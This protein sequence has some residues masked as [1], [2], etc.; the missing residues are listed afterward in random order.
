MPAPGPG[1]SGM[2]KFMAWAIRIKQPKPLRRN[3][4]A[5]TTGASSGDSDRNSAAESSTASSAVTQE[6]SGRG[7]R[8][9]TSGR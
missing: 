3:S 9:R 5:G 8:N 2:S 7:D 4:L 1:S 6:D